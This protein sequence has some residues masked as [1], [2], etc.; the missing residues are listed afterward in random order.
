MRAKLIA[1]FF[2]WSPLLFAQHN[3][4]SCYEN[5]NK[6]K[7]LSRYESAFQEAERLDDNRIDLIYY[8]F[9]WYID[10]AVYYLSGSAD[11]ML[12]ATKD[13]VAFFALELGKD[14]VIDSIVADDHI[15]TYEREGDFN[16]RIYP[17]T[18]LGAGAMYRFKIYY[19]G[20]PA[21]GGLGSFIKDNHNGVPIIWTLSE[22]FGSRDWWPC[23][24]GLTDKIDS[25]DVRIT[26]P[27]AYRAASNGI[28]LREVV[29]DNGSITHHWKHRYAIV[30]Y[31]VAIAV[32]NYERY[33]DT[34]VL[35]NG[36]QLPV[37]NY[38]YP[39]N[40]ND[41]KT[42]TAALMGVL[43]YFD[44]L[45]AGYP[46]HREKYGHAQFG[47]GGGMEHQT[48]SFVVNYGFSLLAHE[49]AHQWFGDMVT[50]GSWED[51]WL[52]EGFATYLEGL[53]R[54]RIQGRPSFRQWQIAKINSASS[55]SGGSV[56]VSDPTNINRIFSGR[57]SY[58]KG[59]YLLHMLRWVLGDEAFFGGLR[60]YL[61]DRKFDF[62]TTENLKFHLE[63]QGQRDLSEFF[64][65]WYSG[66]GYPSYTIHWQPADDGLYLQINQETSHPKV[67]FFEMPL[68]IRLIGQ[69]RDSMVRLDHVYNDQIFELAGV[70]WVDSIEFDPELWIL[71]ARNTV[72]KS[73]I[74]GTT[75]VTAEIQVYPN[76]ASQLLNVHSNQAFDY[77]VFDSMGKSILQGECFDAHL[78]LRVED[79]PEGLYAIRVASR[80]ETRS[81]HFMVSR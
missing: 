1:L 29:N 57:L 18:P 40:L 62:G 3:Y 38:V 44:S 66:E 56:K 46:F 10:P 68:P 19:Q 76:P 5:C 51:I 42:G 6:A 33:S 64:D 16:L 4:G 69:G 80:A 70:N 41:A 23:K 65:D 63:Q 32:T 37:I 72:I 14:M 52:N 43:S 7:I 67:D 45:F 54:W 48:M 71:S 49:L 36:T 28:L 34:I 39:E 30:P 61:N 13:N 27:E 20:A 60:S 11:I 35:G 25:I 59:S 15:L 79:L 31:L 47:W 12:K 53:S 9:D 26:T 77:I 81:Y 21:A 50:C 17:S 75:N 55:Q 2:L 78:Q 24:N 73:E 8:L 22:P 74:V 58:N